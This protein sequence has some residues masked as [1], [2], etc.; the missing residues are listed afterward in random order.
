LIDSINRVL[1]TSI[2]PIFSEARTGDVRESLADITVA[3]ECL[4]YEPTIDFD[5][6]LRR[7]IEY[8]RTLA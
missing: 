2:A 8:Y 4:A 7:S 1:G 6:G 3:R 5:E